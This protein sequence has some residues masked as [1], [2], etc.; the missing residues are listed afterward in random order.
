MDIFSRIESIDSTTFSGRRFSR[1]QI[2]QVVKTVSDFKNLSRTELAHTICEHLNWT[3]PTGSL[4]VNSA[5]ELLDKLQVLGLCQ[6]PPPVSGRKRG[7]DKIHNLEPGSGN[8][9]ISGDLAGISP[10]V[11]ELAVGSVQHHRFNA[12]MAKHHYLGYK[13]PFGAH[14]RYFVRDKDGRELG[15]LL[16]AASAWS[17]KERDEWIGWQKRHRIKRLN[18]IVSNSR[19]LILPHVTVPNLASK[20]LHLTADRLADDWQLRYGYRPV[21]IETFVD[22]SKFL[23][24]C[25][26]ASNWQRLGQTAGLGR[27]NENRGQERVKDFYVKPLVANFRDVLL[28]GNAAV[29]ELSTTPDALRDKLHRVH[30]KVLSFWQETA[31]IIGQV[32]AEYDAVWQIKRRVIDSMLLVML[33]FRLVATRG[34]SGYG[35]AIDE[36][37]ENCRKQGLPLPQKKPIAASA[38]GEARKKLDESI[39]KMINSRVIE[40]YEAQFDADQYRFLGHRVYAVDGTKIN[41]PRPLL[42]DGFILADKACHYPLGLL[43][44]LYRLKAQIP[45]DFALTPCLDERAAALNHLPCLAQGDIVVYDRGYYG[46]SFLY[47]HLRRGINPVFRLKTK[48]TCTAFEE[49]FASSEVDRTIAIAPTGKSGLTKFRKDYPGIP[50]DPIPLRLIKYEIAGAVYCLG[51]TLL[52]DQYTC[53][54]LKDLYHGRWGIEELYKISKQ[55][56]AIEEFHA[57]SLRGVKQELY[58][59]MTMITLNRILTNSAD[60]Q[61]RLAPPSLGKSPK[62]DRATNFKNSLAATARNL[63]CLLLGTYDMLR[64][65][66]I[67]VLASLSRRHQA[68]RPDRSYARQVLRTK[69]SWQKRKRSS[70]AAVK[71]RPKKPVIT[72]PC[73]AS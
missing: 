17:L 55:F 72:L 41:L 62:A 9:P 1:Q 53:E 65:A 11:V 20:I 44:S 22:P 39:F 4:K 67:D 58:A 25:Y 3:T 24:T 21:L 49:F 18:L 38:F 42:A 71:T 70:A 6:P 16:F 68:K 59:H 23:G 7:P 66:A 15:L 30:D 28:R 10:I 12:I 43:S 8:V 60:D 51:T 45:V 19:F 52:G 40:K 32:A 56:I 37:W 61:H 54:R 33:I 63:E 2:L 48:S 13:R 5:L 31:P 69:S 64:S 50:I 36:L 27:F 34:K 26:Q 47:A 35:S 57:K 73:A 46:Y 29:P 14:L